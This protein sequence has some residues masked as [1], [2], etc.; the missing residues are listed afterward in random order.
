M[1]SFVAIHKSL[2]TCNLMFQSNSDL[3]YYYFFEKGKKVQLFYYKEQCCAKV[4][5]VF[6]FLVLTKTVL[7]IDVLAL[8]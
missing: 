7:A 2:L 6:C 4:I 1:T 5:Y 8:Y 3:Y